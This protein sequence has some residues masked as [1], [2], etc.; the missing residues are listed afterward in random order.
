MITKDLTIIGG[1]AAGLAAALAAS[2]PKLD[3]LIIERE[4]QL[5]G[6][7]NQCIHN[8]FGLH[9]YQTELTGPEY[10]HRSIELLDGHPIEIRLN[11]TVIDIQKQ[12]EFLI[13]LSSEQHGYEHIQSRAVIIASGCYERTRGAVQLP[14]ER[15]KGIL[16]AGSAQRYLNM[17][18][19]LV[20]KKVFILGSGDI[21]L[22]MARRMTLEGAEV[23]GVAELMPYSNGLTRN[24]V[25]CL[26]D[27]NIPLYL[28]HTVTDIRGKNVLEQITI[29]QVD[30]Q[31]QPIPGT[32]KV[33]DVDTLLLS[34]GLIPDVGLFDTLQMMKSPVT[35]SAMVDQSLM[36]NVPG[37]FVCGNA[38]HVHDL[39][40]WVSKEGDQAGLS[41]KQ[42]LLENRKRTATLKSVTAGQNIRYVVPHWI[43]FDHI[44]EPIQ[45]SFRVTKKMTS[46]VFKVIQNGQVIVQKK[47]KY[48]AP[49]EMEQILIKPNE[50]ISQDPIEIILEESI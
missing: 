26:D 29:Q 18:G 38:L 3:I 33:F 12:S 19:Y 16:P 21:G 1:G 14:G 50:W 11:T 24:I 32:E 49:A 17:A 34:I 35:K 40:D 37:L 7:L 46:G 13:T 36:T 5:G 20:G 44:D 25:Q 22:I 15:P 48:I 28:S 23:L 10:A 45:C 42:Y 31:F 27:F 4:P 30:A 41:A 9:R 47:A 6:I 8:G 39:V 43:D 2:D